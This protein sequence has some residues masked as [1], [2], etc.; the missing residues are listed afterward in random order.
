VKVKF[1]V[2]EYA[3]KVNA[4]DFHCGDLYKKEI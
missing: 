4:E 2:R 3:V 1:F